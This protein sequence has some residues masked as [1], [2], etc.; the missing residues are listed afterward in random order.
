VTTLSDLL[1]ARTSTTILAAI[2]AEMTAANVSVEGLQTTSILR[3]L[4]DILARLQSTGESA[5]V[6]LTNGGYISGAEAMTGTLASYLDLLGEDFFQ[7]PR[8]PATFTVGKMMV[9]A[10][11]SASGSTIETGN[12]VISYGSG[13]TQVLFTNSEGFTPLPGGAAVEVK[14]TAQVAGV[15][16]NIATGSTLRLVTAYPGLSVTNPVVSGTATWITSRGRDR[17]SQKSY[18]TRIRARWADLGPQTT[19]ER[20][21]T[22]VRYAFTSEDLT[23]PIS[24]LY[25]DDTNPL[26]PGSV[27]LYLATDSGPATADEVTTVEDYV[28]PRWAAGAGELAVYAAGTLSLTVSGQI[29]GPT[30]ETTALEQAQAALE[31]LAAL[32][33][34]GGTTVYLEQIRTALMNTVTGAVNVTLS[35]PAADTA[36]PAGSIVEFTLGSMTVVP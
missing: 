4:P 15:S 32:Y 18:A 3:A 28:T 30:N 35:L 16:G 17:E 12:F 22:L 6:A 23:N 2:Y 1:T 8:D 33:P 31:A 26:G 5:R 29:K 13:S 11:S 19:A 21:A 24:R 27:A 25:V 9:A 20:F 34:I 14:M 7:L 10:Q 36:I